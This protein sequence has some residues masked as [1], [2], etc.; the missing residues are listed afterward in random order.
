MKANDERPDGE[1]LTMEQA[2]EEVG[3]CGKY[4][5]KRMRRLLE[6]KESEFGKSIVSR[7]GKRGDRKITRGSLRY[8]CP[9]LFKSSIDDMASKFRQSLTEIDIKLDRR[10]SEHPRIVRIISDQKSIRRDLNALAERV[11]SAI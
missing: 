3:W 6:R 4:R 10:I 5:W 7:I 11:K 2:A 9:E 1:L 8:Y